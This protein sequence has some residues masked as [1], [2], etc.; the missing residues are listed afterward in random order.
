MPDLF[1]LSALSDILIDAL[2]ASDDK[3]VFVETQA[4]QE[5]LFAAGIYS[6][7]MPNNSSSVKKRDQSFAKFAMPGLLEESTFKETELPLHK[8]LS[9]DRLRFWYSPGHVQTTRLLASLKSKRVVVDFNIH[10]TLP[11]IAAGIFE[12]TTAYKVHDL[13]SREVIDFLPHAPIDELIVSYDDEHKLLQPLF[14]NCISLGNK[15]PPRNELSDEEKK[16]IRENLDIDEDTRILGIIFD[17]RYDWKITGILS[18]LAEMNP[19]PSLPIFIYVNSYQERK[20]LSSCVPSFFFKWLNI[21]VYDS[22]SLMGICDEIMYPAYDERM[23]KNIPKVPSEIFA[24]YG[25][26]DKAHLFV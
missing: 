24:D 8:V 21:R 25:N 5:R 19:R 26:I 13:F 10:S 16:R 12:H 3:T 4:L 20:K 18:E 22:P 2:I 11:W 1:V 17:H 15:R 23:L 7:V 9:I 14:E 6:A